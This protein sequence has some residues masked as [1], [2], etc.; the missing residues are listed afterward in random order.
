[1]SATVGRPS[2]TTPPSL[3]EVVGYRHSAL[4]TYPAVCQPCPPPDSTCISCA[5]GPMSLC[6]LGFWVL[7]SPG[8][9]GLTAVRLLSTLG[10]REITDVGPVVTMS[11]VHQLGH[12][13]VTRTFR[14]VLPLIDRRNNHRPVEKRHRIYRRVRRSLDSARPLPHPCSETVASPQLKPDSATAIAPLRSIKPA[15]RP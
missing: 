12:G 11:F 10:G 13:A 8:R 15:A 5:A 6:E 9:S 4:G 3:T 14:V 2:Q 1:M 7:V